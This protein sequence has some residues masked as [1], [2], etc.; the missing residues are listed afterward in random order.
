MHT[1]SATSTSTKVA[2]FFLT[3]CLKGRRREHSEYDVESEVVNVYDSLVPSCDVPLQP[4][5]DGI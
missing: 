4:I 5:T 2:A 3:A 1:Y